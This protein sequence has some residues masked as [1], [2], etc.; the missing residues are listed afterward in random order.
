[1]V[2]LYHSTMPERTGIKSMHKLRMPADMLTCQFDSS[3]SI[4]RANV[5]LGRMFLDAKDWFRSTHN[6]EFDRYSLT[7]GSLMKPRLYSD[8]RMAQALGIL[9]LPTVAVEKIYLP[10]WI[11]TTVSEISFHVSEGHVHQILGSGHSY[12]T[13]AMN[14]GLDV[15]GLCS[16]T[17]AGFVHTS[18]DYLVI[19]LRGGANFPTT[20]YFSAG[21]LTTTAMSEAGGCSVYEYY[22]KGELRKEYGLDPA[23]VSN[24]ELLC[25]LEQSGGSKDVSYVFVVKTPLTLAEVLGRYSSNKDPDKKEHNHLFGIR[26]EA[27]LDFVT[28]YYRGIAKNDPQRAYQDRVLLP[29]GAAPLL[30]YAGQSIELI[31]DLAKLHL[32]PA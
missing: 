29:Q 16:V 25:R 8:E 15:R 3:D 7:D 17:V 27:V 1:M 21:S 23:D 9:G 30:L 4:E 24:A 2:L 26:P 18:D 22:A 6:R 31:D 32:Q 13:Q 5:L 12:L 11:A 19:G 14:Q 28:T 10:W 20:Y